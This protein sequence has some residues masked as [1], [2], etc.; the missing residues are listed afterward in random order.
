MDFRFCPQCG[1]KLSPKPCGDEGDVPF[2][3]SCNR[4]FFAFS[5]PC[6]LCLCITE[7]GSEIALIKQS[8]VS[9]NYVSVAGYIKQ[10]ETAEETAVREVKEEIGLDVI[11]CKYISSYYYPKHDNLMLGYVCTVRKSELTISPEV[12]S[13]EWFPIESAQQ[14]LRNASVLHR[15]LDNYLHTA[16]ITPCGQK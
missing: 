14:L 3:E 6:V 1:A 13:A 9:K 7:N 16:D 10:G 5:Y 4:P 11:S 15:L 2:C 8:Y 12:D